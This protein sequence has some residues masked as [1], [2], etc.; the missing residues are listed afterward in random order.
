MVKEKIFNNNNNERFDWKKRDRVD[1]YKYVI[2][3]I[4]NEVLVR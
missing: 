1:V 2:R 4:F 3:R